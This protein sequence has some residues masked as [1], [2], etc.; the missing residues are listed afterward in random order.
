MKSLFFVVLPL[1]VAACATPMAT[2]KSE[3][4]ARTSCCKSVA[5]F[6]FDA[7]DNEKEHELA[8]GSSSFVFDF[9]T[10]K[11]YFAS[12]KLPD[13]TKRALLIKSQFNGTYIGQFLQP[14]FTFLDS[15]KREVST[16]S[17]RLSFIP[18]AFV[19]YTVAHMSG[20]IAVPDSAEFVVVY[21]K[22]F[23]NTA[24]GASVPQAPTVFTAGKVPVVVPNAPAQRTFELSPSGVL[25]LKP[26]A[27]RAN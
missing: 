5:E 3:L 10:G 21:T 11:S 13:G 24:V 26:F 6:K 8:L 18:P 25:V 9:P 27:A 12:Y 7:L 23:S 16:F 1:L 4:N 19:P 15:E 22:D 20:G 14:I 2:Q 17:P